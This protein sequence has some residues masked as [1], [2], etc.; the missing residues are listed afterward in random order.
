MFLFLIF[1]TWFSFFSH[2]KAPDWMS[3]QIQKDLEAFSQKKI[4]LDQMEKTFNDPAGFFIKIQFKNNHFIY[5][6]VGDLKNQKIFA[7]RFPPMKRAFKELT[8]KYRIPDLTFFL[9]LDDHSSCNLEYPLFVMSKNKHANGPILFPDFFALANGFQVIPEKD[10]R[11]FLTPWKN[12]QEKLIW[13]GATTQAI[14][15]EENLLKIPRAIL[16]RLSKEHPELIDAK[17]TILAQGA[18]HIK[19]CME[20]VGKKISYEEIFNYKYQ[21]WIDGNGVSYSDS[22]WRFFTN[23]V[24][25]KTESDNIQWYFG[26]LQPWVHYVPIK[27]NLDDLFEKIQLIQKDDAL[28][29]KLA[30]NAREFAL[31]RIPREKCLEYFYHLLFAYSKLEFAK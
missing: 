4:S 19:A 12:K 5:S 18:E 7:H 14:Y 17:F 10:L 22:G 1:S 11:T 3:T 8:K 24:L 28:A 26:D 31:E 9:T 25:F 20:Y 23:S 27:E 6:C 21:I 29:I 2:S 30:Q 13:R 15:N 16:C